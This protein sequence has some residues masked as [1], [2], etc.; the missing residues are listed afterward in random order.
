MQNFIFILFHEKN[1]IQSKNNTFNTQSGQR[2]AIK[3]IPS[4]RIPLEYTTTFTHCY[5]SIK[6]F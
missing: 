2:L 3:P 6:I 1:T 5:E 4:F